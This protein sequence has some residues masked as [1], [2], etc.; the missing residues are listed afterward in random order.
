MYLWRV[1][2]IFERKVFRDYVLVNIDIVG[3]RFERIVLM[4]GFWGVSV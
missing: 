3:D 2:G 1:C 4:I